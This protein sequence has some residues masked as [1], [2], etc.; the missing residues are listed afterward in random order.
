MKVCPARR[1]FTRSGISGHD[2]QPMLFRM[3]F[4]FL[5]PL[6]YLADAPDC[7]CEIWAPKNCKYRW[8]SLV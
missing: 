4:P 7:P 1:E 3:P 6:V 5:F 2:E 8:V